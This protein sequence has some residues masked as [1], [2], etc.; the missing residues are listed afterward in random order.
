VSGE[1]Y[2]GQAGLIDIRVK[3]HH[4]CIYL[5]S[6]D[7]S[8]DTRHSINLGHHIQTPVSSPLYPDVWIIS[9]GK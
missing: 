5:K 6:L 8:G 7:M 1:I 4:Q 9:S 3:I 2:N